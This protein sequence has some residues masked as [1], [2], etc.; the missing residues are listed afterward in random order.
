[1]GT[2]SVPFRYLEFP[3]AIGGNH[4][5]TRTRHRRLPGSASVPEPGLKLDFGFERRHGRGSYPDWFFLN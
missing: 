4:T 2:K 3:H 1:M 5:Q